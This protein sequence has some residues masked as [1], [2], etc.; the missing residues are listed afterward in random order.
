MPQDANSVLSGTHNKLA[1][2]RLLYFSDAVFAI[3]ITLLALELRLPEGVAAGGDALWAALGGMWPKYLSFLVSFTVIGL[4]W[5]GHHR[6]FR[7]INRFDDRLLWINL[8]FLMCI[9]VIPFPTSVLGEHANR[10]AAVVF[11]ACVL[12][13]TGLLQLAMWVYATV[14]RRLVEATLDDAQYRFLLRLVGARMAIPPLVFLLS[15]AA[16][17]RSPTWVEYSWV[18]MVP[19]LALVGLIARRTRPG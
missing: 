13:L 14:G 18:L 7:L 12:A 11:Y 10:P 6:M 8:L 9:V 1:F 17:Q 5:Q 3:A 2:D 19:A 15:I 16:A 4:Y